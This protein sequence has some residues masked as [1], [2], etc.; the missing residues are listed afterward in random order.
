MEEFQDQLKT[1]FGIAGELSAK[2]TDKDFFWKFYAD[3]FY[4][5]SKS[6]QMP[7]FTRLITVSVNQQENLAWFKEHP[8]ELKAFEAWV[9]AIPRS[10]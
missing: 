5:L 2:K 7:V 1:I 9:R 4:Q 3:Y 6:E 10:F 8:T